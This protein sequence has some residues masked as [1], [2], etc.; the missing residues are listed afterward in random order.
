MAGDKVITQGLANLKQGDKVRPVPQ[1]A[2]Q[3][4]AAPKG[5]KF[6]GKSAGKRPG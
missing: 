6:G 2:P 3:K 4:V 1:N 5:G